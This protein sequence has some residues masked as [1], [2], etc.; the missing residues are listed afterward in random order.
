MYER[1]YGFAERP[2][3]LLPDPDFLYPSKSHQ[4]ALSLLEMA[5]VNACGFCVISGEIGAGKTTLVR[6]LLNRLDKQV[7]VGLVS[8]T[9]PSFGELLQW[10][11]AAYGLPCASH[12]KVEFHRRFI[13]FAIQQYAANKR[14]LLII[15]EAQNL[16]P[17]ALE[18]L[19]MLSNVNS[20]KDLVLQIILIGQRQLRD[21]LKDPRLEQFAQRIA[22][23]YHLDSLGVEETRHYIRHRLQHAGGKPTLFSESAF[24]LIHEHTAGIPRLINRLCDLCLVYGCAEQ[25]ALLD[26]DLVRRVADDQH[27]GPLSCGLGVGGWAAQSVPLPPAAWTTPDKARKSIRQAAVASGEKRTE[28]GREKAVDVVNRSFPPK[29]RVARVASE[30]EVRDKTLPGTGDNLH[31]LVVAAE[32]R[33]VSA[34]RRAGWLLL[35]ILMLVGATVLETRELWLQKFGEALQQVALE[36][37][38]ITRQSLTEAAGPGKASEPVAR[39]AAIPE[40]PSVSVMAGRTL[41]VNSSKIRQLATSDLAQL[42]TLRQ[43]RALQREAERVQ[44]LRREAQRLEQQRR[45]AEKRLARQRVKRQALE[46]EARIQQQRVQATRKINEPVDFDRVQAVKSLGNEGLY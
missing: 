1:F 9:H 22:L 42:A 13:Q 2:F 36:V 17:A 23:D 38:S 6:E 20:D 4:T 24:R 39:A 10:I 44:Q 21:N 18:E 8:N 29:Q 33:A 19:R 31:K 28:G 15:D 34:K 11:M 35:G 32:R 45:A 16:T 26:V 37:R 25:Y 43:Q 3:S 12:D 7:R 5:V 14:T 41:P 40:S 27:I 30:D 46:R